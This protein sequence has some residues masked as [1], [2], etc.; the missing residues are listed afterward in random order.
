MPSKSES[1][2]PR[3]LRFTIV[4]YVFN[5]ERRAEFVFNISPLGI[6]SYVLGKLR[7]TQTE[8]ESRYPLP[9]SLRIKFNV[10]RSDSWMN[11]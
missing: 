6:G 4:E 9:R 2:D 7:L 8:L 5:K 1:K 11:D 3:N 10:D